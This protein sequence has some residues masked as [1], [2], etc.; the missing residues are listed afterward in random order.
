MSAAQKMAAMRLISRNFSQRAVLRTRNCAPAN[1]ATRSNDF[2]L[3]SASA[4]SEQGISSRFAPVTVRH[5][6]S[7]TQPEEFVKNEIES[8]K[9]RAK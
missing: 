2:F 7:S 1:L 3:S 9:V 4:R 8:N 5:M 6:S